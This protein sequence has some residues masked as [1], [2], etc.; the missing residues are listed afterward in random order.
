M[1]ES[2]VEQKVAPAFSHLAAKT[3]QQCLYAF[4]YMI[5]LTGW[6]S[7]WEFWN[8]CGWVLARRYRF[9]CPKLCWIWPGSEADLFT[10]M[11]STI[12]VTPRLWNELPQDFVQILYRYM[13]KNGSH[14]NVVLGLTCHR[15]KMQPRPLGPGWT[16]CQHLGTGLVP[17][18]EYGTCKL[19]IVMKCIFQ[20]KS[21]GV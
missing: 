21:T 14:F 11:I 6:W 3:Y 10:C 18:V 15:L 1:C 4:W 8:P 2:F 17:V 9:I 5:Y 16:C 19:H 20:N 13:W 12:Y 7:S